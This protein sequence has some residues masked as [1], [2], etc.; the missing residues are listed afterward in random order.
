[1]TGPR[2]NQFVERAEANR[3][4][5]ERRRAVLL[6]AMASGRELYSVSAAQVLGLDDSWRSAS[7]AK[8]LLIGLEADGLAFSRIA[9]APGAWKRRY[10]RLA[11]ARSIGA[12]DDD[13]SE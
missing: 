9:S 5:R 1:M 12:V 10:F 4:E 13:S 6:G 8:A 11:R 2:I 7:A 3:P